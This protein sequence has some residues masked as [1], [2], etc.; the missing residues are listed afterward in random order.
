MP[1]LAILHVLIICGSDKIIA[2]EF[3]LLTI[4]RSGYK[5]A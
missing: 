4:T 1:I 2:I 3:F 5:I